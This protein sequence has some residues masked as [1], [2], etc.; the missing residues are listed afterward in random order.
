MNE[1]LMPTALPITDLLLAGKQDLSQ[2]P[3][4]DFEILPTKRSK[5]WDL[6]EANRCA[7]VGT[8]LSLDELVNFAQR[9]HF[10]ASLSD[11]FSLH[12]EMI[13]RIATR[14]SVSEAIQKHLD[15]KYQ[16]SLARFKS[17]KTDAEVLNLWRKCFAHGDI[18]GALWAA[19]THK[20][21]SNETRG[22]IYGDIHMHSHQMGAGQAI[23]T[24]R[25][26][27]LEK[28]YAEME[29]AM[30]LQKQ[31][32]VYVEAK[33]RRRLQE[34]LAEIEHLRQAQKDM[35][36]LQVRL[37]AIESGRAI[38]EMGQRLMKLAVANEQL[39]SSAKQATFLEQALQVANGKIAE[40][41]H[42]CNVLTAER[43][44]LE[45]LLQSSNVN[46]VPCNP[47]HFHNT[48][49][50][51][52]CCVICVGGHVTQ[53]PKYRLLAQQLGIYLIHHDGGQNDALSR[54]P[55]M[56][57]RANAAI[58][59]TDCVSH[60][61]YYRLKRLCKRNGKPC[62][63]FKGNGISS[64][65]SVLTQISSGQANLRSDVIERLKEVTD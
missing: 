9:Y 15:L 19:L 49:Q 6:K 13:D 30:A 24:R 36:A 10:N 40:L 5:I 2:F 64:F 4:S 23:N 34:I 59:P 55:E 3:R 62:L 26:A 1:S 22:K 21:V 54:L 12:I 7:I 32:H 20:Q 35:S 18:A 53:F 43:D 47:S 65:A 52:N 39:Q 46:N 14:N 63:L 11:T 27:Q 29:V 50:I 41:T 16:I 37:A 45:I 57:N 38:T 31:R 56:I 58:C 28:D 44:S 48:S 42:E 17:A 61:A 51:K 8:C 60:A 25:L 33:L